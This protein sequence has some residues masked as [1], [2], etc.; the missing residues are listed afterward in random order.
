[1]KI[2]LIGSD[3][4]SVLPG[5]LADMF[6]AQK[7]AGTLAVHEPNQALGDLLK[8]Y[9]LAVIGKSGIAGSLTI[10][11]DLE[12]TL[13]GADAVI[14]ADSLQNASRFQMDVSALSG[15]NEEDEGLKNQARVH[16]GIEGLLFTLR[17]GAKALSLTAQMEAHCPHALVLNLSQP[18][19]QIT[20]L[21]HLNGFECYGFG[22]TALTGKAGVEGLC[23]VIS[24]KQSG[25]TFQ[26]AGLYRF[27]WLTELKETMSGKDLLPRAVQAYKNGAM[28]QGKKLFASWYGALPIGEGHGESL[29]Q[30][31]CFTPDLNPV[32]AE[33]IEKRKERLL[34]MNEVVTHGLN[35]PYGQLAQLAL[36]KNVPAERPIQC[37]L[38]GE[39]YP[40]PI[41]RKANGSIKGLLKDSVIQATFSQTNLTLP[42]GVMDIV[43]D[44]AYGHQLCAKAAMG[45][46]EALREYIETSPALSGLDRLY[47]Q[48]L[49]MHLIRLHEDVLPLYG[50]D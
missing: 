23:H 16:D 13:A 5:F 6:Y 36:I 35:T 10:H 8:K 38:M 12:A 47:L 25:L 24:K 29:P 14:F 44:V 43:S 37:L 26:T 15:E 45:D 28:G 4:P 31:D 20:A 9:A 2:A 30:N 1:M 11:K 32:L 46:Q 42:Q 19:S 18:L 3:I 41:L 50:L 22:E 39:A 34:H 33:S 27:Q 40:L 7:A 17:T 21:F 48:S 49:V